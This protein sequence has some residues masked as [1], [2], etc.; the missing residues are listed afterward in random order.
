MTREQIIAA[1]T[2][3]GQGIVNIGQIHAD[4]GDY[5]AATADH[6]DT[7]YAYKEGEALF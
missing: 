1:Q 7:F 3:W 5:Q 2:A 6:I 4:G